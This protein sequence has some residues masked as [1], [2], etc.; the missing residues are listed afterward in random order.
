MAGAESVAAPKKLRL[1]AKPKF[2]FPIPLKA[3]VLDRDPGAEG[4]GE[5]RLE[6]DDVW[7]ARGFVA[8]IRARRGGIDQPAN[9]CLGFAD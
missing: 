6:L 1:R 7:V 5:A 9:Q 2:A 4:V 8:T 3:V